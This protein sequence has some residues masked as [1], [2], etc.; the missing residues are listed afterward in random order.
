MMHGRERRRVPWGGTVG[1][2]IT[3]DMNTSND[4]FWFGGG[5]QTMAP[6]RTVRPYVA[7]TTG[8]SNFQTNSTLEGRNDE[9]ERRQHSHLSHRRDRGSILG[10][11]RSRT[12]A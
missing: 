9:L 11:S 1:G 2:R 3:L 7:A 12:R 5:L 4:L 8:L 10:A 6:G